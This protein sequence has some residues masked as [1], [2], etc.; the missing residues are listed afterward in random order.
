MIPGLNNISATYVKANK[1]YVLQ[2]ER[3]RRVFVKD[4]FGHGMQKEEA[5]NVWPRLPMMEFD[6][7]QHQKPPLQ[8]QWPKGN[9]NPT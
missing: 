8:C 3:L 2:K 7:S 6:E 9:K 5:C 4:D 1:L